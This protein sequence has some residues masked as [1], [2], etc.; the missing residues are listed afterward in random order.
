MRF[1]NLTDFLHADV[2]LTK[3]LL[4]KHSPEVKNSGYLSHCIF[5]AP[6]RTIYNHSLTLRKINKAVNSGKTD[7]T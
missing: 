2:K 5:V 1:K 4:E 7:F 3:H 6:N